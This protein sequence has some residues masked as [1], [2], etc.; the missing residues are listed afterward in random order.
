[1]RVTSRFLRSRVLACLITLVGPSTACPVSADD[2]KPLALSGFAPSGGQAGTTVEVTASGEF[3]TWPLEVWTDRGGLTWKPLEE[4]GHFEVS[5]PPAGS[6]GLHRVRFHDSTG[7]TVVKRFLVGNVAEAAEIEPNDTLADAASVE[8]FPQTING[9]LEKAGDVDSFQVHLQAGETLVASLEANRLLGSPVDAVLELVDGGG[10][11]LARNLDASGLDPR[12]AYT[13]PRDGVCV[14]R[15]YGFPSAPNSTIGLAGG[16]DYLYRLTLTTAGFVSGCLPTVA[17]ADVA[18]ALTPVGWNLPDAPA[19][20][21]ITP[22]GERTT[23]VAFAGVAGVLEVPVVAENRVAVAGAN[24]SPD[25]P[26]TPPFIVSG[27]FTQANDLHRYVV[28]ASKDQKLQ[29]RLESQKIG[30]EAD[31]LL[32]IRDA[33]GASR[34]AKPERDAAFTWTAEADGHTTFEVRDRRGRF[35]P[36]HLYRLTV[37]PEQPTFTASATSDAFT[38]K[39]DEPVTIEIAIDRKHGFAE[40]LEFALDLAPEGVTAEPVVSANEGDAA[41]KVTLTLTATSPASGVVRIIARP[42]TEEAATGDA[43]ATPTSVRFGSDALR[44]A[45]LTILPTPPD[46][47]ATPPA[48]E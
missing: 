39:A 8:A 9:R 16:A 37:E 35:G 33:E 45:W 1:M 13:A 15:V 47:D 22:I 17:V 26:L 27:Q 5:I 44:E 32:V 10:A 38:A 42:T 2:T 24:A 11:Y 40:S 34:M 3:P 18:T 14:V 12:V 4:A 20:L 6:F 19:P 29:V 25:T 43:A 36:G 41:K 31:P 46:T 28:A 23:W 21:A 48:T 7:A 30:L